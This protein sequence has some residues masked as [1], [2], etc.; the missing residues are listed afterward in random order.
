[1]LPKP[2][3]V[4]WG[5]LT[6]SEVKKFG[7]LA[8]ALM[9]TVGPY[10][11]LRGVREALF[12]DLVGIRW[13]PWG[14]I[15]SLL[16][17]IPL[18]LIYSKLVDLVKK[19]KL[20]YVVY[21]SY[22]VLFVLIAFFVEFP[23]TLSASTSPLFAW[24]P[25]QG[26]GWVS[27]VIFESFGALAVA[28]FWSFVA[29]YTTTDS[30][31]RGYGMII[32]ITQIGTIGGSLFIAN[33]AQKLGLPF[34]ILIATSFIII[35][36][37]IIRLYLSQN[38]EEPA[39]A[40]FRKDKPKT[41]FLEGLRLL[42]KQPYLL[43]IFIVTT[44]YEAIGVFLEFQMNLLAHS[45]YPTKELFAEF[46]GRYG[47]YTNGLAFI[48]A[49]VGT[50]FFLRTFGLRICLLLFPIATATIVCTTRLFPVLPVV[51]GSMIIL[52][53]MSYSLNT[54]SKEILYIPTSRDVRFKT[55]GWIDIFGV[56]SVK[57]S[58]AGINAFLGKLA[59]A[60]SIAYITPVLL[61][62]AS[63]WLI[64]ARLV[65]IKHHKLEKK[66]QIIE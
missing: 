1:M 13:Q 44:G 58:G 31:K 65:G 9:C 33:Y 12:I 30:A 37:F 3:R 21:F 55:K 8:L 39:K 17:I 23:Q 52:K 38:N 20:F 45:R 28:L 54:P 16:F 41:G 48:F 66:N 22:A 34:I 56:R 62:L 43:G 64:V 2:L 24:I 36:P 19:E 49:L 18:I 63:G 6:L 40:F 57:A 50:S 51:L 27:Y 35:V 14:K 7:L 26:L 47:F 11:M 59:P 25:G 29:S 60:E 5:D 61:F 32:S 4:V 53:G 15:A 42:L 10:W 46:Y